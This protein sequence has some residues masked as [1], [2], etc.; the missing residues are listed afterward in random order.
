[1]L[2]TK[3]SAR[4]TRC[5]LHAL[6]AP[7]RGRYTSARTP[8]PSRPPPKRN[9]FTQQSVIFPLLFPRPPDAPLQ[10]FQRDI[11]KAR[12]RLLAVQGSLA[13]VSEEN[14][15]LRRELEAER[16]KMAAGS[17]R[18]EDAVERQEHALDGVRRDSVQLR[19][20]RDR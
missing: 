6:L 14:S 9:F 12:H 7:C 8:R 11:D 13:E 5:P 17:R 15:G 18:L 20:Q 1:M 19:E 10:G 3:S 4:N 2:R 16:V